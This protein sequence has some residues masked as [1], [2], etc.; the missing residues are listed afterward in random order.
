MTEKKTVFAGKFLLALALFF[1]VGYAV[2][3]FSGFGYSR[4]LS[5]YGVIGS[6]HNP[7]WTGRISPDVARGTPTWDVV[8]A[9]A[10][11]EADGGSQYVQ[12]PDGRPDLGGIDLVL[13]GHSL[14]ED[15]NGLFIAGTV[16]NRSN[17]AFDA[18]RIAFDLCDSQ[19]RPYNYVT[20]TATEIMEPGDS[21]GFTI[22][23]PYTEMGMFSS[24]RL[25][26]IMGVTN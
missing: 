26:S 10:P 7:Q 25:Q 9:Q 8:P 14:G 17:H 11:T 5:G 24:Y 13:S 21:W 23:I 4:S 15:E 16:V 19:N 6:S 3:F 2:G 20:D 18:V 22:Y 12:D 1:G